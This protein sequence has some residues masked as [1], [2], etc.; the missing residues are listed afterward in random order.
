MAG[1]DLAGWLRVTLVRLG[2]G[3]VFVGRVRA[4]EGNNEAVRVFEANGLVFGVDAA[5]R[6]IVN[7]IVASDFEV[8]ERRVVDCLA[9]SGLV[10]RSVAKKKRDIT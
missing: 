4:H 10:L 1:L 8:H 7:G 9:S 2:R 3:M 6:A 5:F